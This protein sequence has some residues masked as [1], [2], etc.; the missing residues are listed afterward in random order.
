MYYIRTYSILFYIVWMY[1]FIS[2]S[3]H[4]IFR[5]RASKT[6]KVPFEIASF[7]ILFLRFAGD[8]QHIRKVFFIWQSCQAW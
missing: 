7:I 8:S 6:G 5:D 3:F 2:Y 4:D 1:L